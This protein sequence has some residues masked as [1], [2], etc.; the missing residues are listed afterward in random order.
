MTTAT[1]QN[2]FIHRIIPATKAGKAPLL[3]LHGTGGN[4]DSLLPVAE[5]AAPGR[6]VLSPRGRVMENGM[7]RF[8]RRFAEGVFDEEDVILR[9][10]ELADFV[11]EKTA[12]LQ[13]SKPVAIGFSNGA[14]IA[15]AL[16][17]LRPDVLGGAILLRAMTP[18]HKVQS[19]ADLTGQSV[20]MLS[21][22]ADPIVPADDAGELA[23]MLQ[24][25]GAKVSHHVLPAGHGL[26]AQDLSIAAE[27]INAMP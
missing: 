2:T 24:S 17:L 27:F 14:N 20:L 6:A 7:P 23:S 4:E 5:A 15:A 18:L 9:A 1:L 19:T 8:F 25:R 26:T 11:V 22:S 13:W 12:A 21:G 16:M 10:N 3:L